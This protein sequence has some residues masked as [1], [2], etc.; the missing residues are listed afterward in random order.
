MLQLKPGHWIEVEFRHDNK[1]NQAR[2]IMVMRPVG[3]PDT[4]P[5]KEQPASS[6]RASP[7]R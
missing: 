2:R 4:A 5:E 3:G 7:G 6:E 1:D